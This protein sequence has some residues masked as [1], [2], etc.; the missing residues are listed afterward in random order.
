MQRGMHAAPGDSVGAPVQ[1]WRGAAWALPDQAQAGPAAAPGD[2]PL[3]ER[4][5][6]AVLARAGDGA[7][8]GSSS[9]AGAAGQQQSSQPHAAAAA[10]GGS[11]RRAGAAAAEVVELLSDSEE[12]GAQEGTP[13][14]A[15]PLAWARGGAAQA[16]GDGSVAQLVDM[17]FT[18]EQA[19]QVP[20]QVICRLKELLCAG[21]CCLSLA[22]PAGHLQSAAKRLGCH[23]THTESHHLAVCALDN[24]LSTP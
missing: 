20:C 3:R 2:L 6:A 5:A 1:A 8:P 17:G 16:A 9:G 19:E 24:I 23:A 22:W 21:P 15:A 7:A 4:L 13:A 11:M 10:Q 18:P 12:E 14:A